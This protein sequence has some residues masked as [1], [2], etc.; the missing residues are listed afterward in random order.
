MSVK[1]KI[2][3]LSF[4]LFL[5]TEICVSS[6]L[7]LEFLHGIDIAPSVLS[8][9]KEFPSGKYYVDI[10]F[11][12]K[13]V[14][15]ELLIIEE[16]D[17]NVGPCIKSEWLQKFNTKIN[18]DKYTAFFDSTGLCYRLGREPH[19]KVKFDYGSQALRLDI[20][21]A[22]LLNRTDEK[23]WDYG[24]TGARVK[25]YSNINK[26]NKGN[27]S[28]FGNF[29]LSANLDRWILSNSFNASRTNGDSSIS[30]NNLTLSTAIGDIQGELKIGRTQTRSQ[31]YP[32]FGYYGVSLHSN[33]NMS[34]WNNRGYAPI[35]DGVANS[36]SRVTVLQGDY[37]VY[38]KIVPPGPYQLDDIS[39]V[40]NGDLTV[41]VE[42]ANGHKTTTTYPVSTLPTLLRPNSLE[43]NFT[44]G[45]KNNSTKYRD[46]FTSNSNSG[47]FLEGEIGYGFNKTT[48]NTSTIL[49]SKY[50]SLG[51]GS[52]QSLG[53]YGAFET[54]LIASQASYRGD[55][56]SGSAF[57][58]KYAKSIGEKT[59]IQLLTYRRKSRNYIDFS[60]FS[61]DLAPYDNHEKSR[62]EARLSHQLESSYL[63]VSYWKQEHWKHDNDE[64]GLT[65]SASSYL[66]RISFYLNSSYSKRANNTDDY[67]ISLGF[68]VPISVAEPST[69]S[70]SSFSYSRSS[71]NSF[72]T[73]LSSRVDDKLNYNVNAN[74]DDKGTRVLTGGLS[75]A[76]DSAQTS[77]SVSQSRGV[78]SASGGVSGSVL[79]TDK[80]GLLFSKETSETI[81]IVNAESLDG[82]KFNDSMPTNRKGKTVVAL[83]PYTKN[84]ININMNSAPDNIEFLK[85]SYDVSPTDGAIIYRN[86]PFESINRYILHVRDRA[87][88]NI[89]GGIAKT[90]LGVEVGFIANNGILLMNTLAKPDFVIVNSGSHQCKFSMSHINANTNSVQ[91]VYCE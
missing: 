53:A 85:T 46:M 47:V 72:N 45:R 80:A 21:Q 20:P 42:D 76:F 54:N 44:I 43:Y 89:H 82:I 61:S 50:K 69:Y 24:S 91:E 67:S 19:T 49:H 13:K 5:H 48:L 11:N 77:F 66:N 4:S 17:E 33:R 8:S 29:D 71:G 81:A 63:N 73:S 7:N 10:F 40:S 78:K 51:L 59:D 3:I 57:N 88:N 1:L 70:N 79:L 35:I 28:T 65:L 22:Y 31:M 83:T 16:N 75:Y 23:D 64:K 68:S 55:L 2:A 36:Q 74:V 90:N 86:F 41:I 25:Y 84:K 18:E 12:N 15:R 6:E 30:T 14:G 60:D 87:G 56:R 62:Y 39:P 27:I 58:I 34:T 26:S 37:T 9:N 52:T 32:D 38:S